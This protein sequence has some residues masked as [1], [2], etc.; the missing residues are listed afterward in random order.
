MTALA[1]F[2]ETEKISQQAFAAKIGASQSLV[3]KIASG[4]QRPGID[5]AVRI[6]RATRGRIEAMSWFAAPKKSKGH[7]RVAQ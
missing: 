7:P 2:L 1:K 3:S 5:V 6:E 4:A